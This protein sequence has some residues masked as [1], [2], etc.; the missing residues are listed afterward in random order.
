MGGR[1]EMVVGSWTGAG[2]WIARVCRRAGG[3]YGVRVMVGWV[4]GSSKSDRGSDS[5]SDSNAASRRLRVAVVI[6]P[7]VV[8]SLSRR[9][10]SAPPPSFNSSHHLTR[11]TDTP[12]SQRRSTNPEPPASGARRAQRRRL[13]TRACERASCDRLAGACAGVAIIYI[14][15]IMDGCVFWFHWDDRRG[16]PLAV[17]SYG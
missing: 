9:K 2:P 4:W 11:M 1:V 12:P 17:S 16:K 7:S 3:R 6:V 8:L 15:C 5:D 14:E 10:P 13:H